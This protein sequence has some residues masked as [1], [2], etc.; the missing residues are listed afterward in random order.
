MTQRLAGKVAIVTGAGQ[1]I[2]RAIAVTLSREG[3]AVVAVDMNRQ[4]V[5]D[6]AAA[7][8]GE[9]LALTCNVTDSAEVAAVFARCEERFGRLDILVNN[10]G[11]GQAPGDGSDLY[12]QRMAERGAQLARGETPT[13]YADHTIDMGD[14]GWLAVMNVNINGTFYCCREALRLMSRLDIAGAIV[15][16]SSTSA[17]CGEGGAHYCASK[18]AILGLTKSLAQEVGARGIR[19]N[20]VAP[21]PTRTPA[22]A[23]ISREWQDQIARGVLLERL[24]EPEEIANAVLFLASG[25][26][27][28]CTGQTLCA[29]GGMHLL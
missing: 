18:A 19:V 13:V 25:E 11:I 23:G 21:G 16:I 6:T 27:S 14:E 4:A 2:G 20:A 12:Q 10:A 29:N 1:G 17:L 3:A 22:M 7:C 9:A 15:N 28:Y 5:E 8:P 24:A 26:G